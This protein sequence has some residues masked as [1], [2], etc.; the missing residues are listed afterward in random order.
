MKLLRG[1]NSLSSSV[2][3]QIGFLLFYAV[4]IHAGF[5]VLTL[6]FLT[7]AF[8]L[9][10]VAT[11]S[12]FLIGSKY[13][14]SKT[15]VLFYW[16]TWLEVSVHVFT[17][18]KIFGISL[19]V[20]LYYFVLISIGSYIFLIPYTRKL[21]ALFYCVC[22]V[23]NGVSYM[24]VKFLL[25]MPGMGFMLANPVYLTYFMYSVVMLCGM[26][27]LQ[28]FFFARCISIYF[29]SINEKNTELD[30]QAN[31]D[32][33]TELYNRRKMNESLQVAF[34]RH[35]VGF[36]PLSLCLGDIDNFKMI[37]DTYGHNAGDYVLKTIGRILKANIRKS[38]PVGRW[39]GEEFVFFM[40]ADENACYARA[41]SVRKEIESYEFVFEERRIPVTITFGVTSSGDDTPDVFSLVEKADRNLYRGKQGGRNQTVVG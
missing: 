16:V 11:I 6:I 5:L 24:A 20:E 9:F 35:K 13:A 26:V 10:Y 37:N 25:P 40:H 2:D 7:P 33:L 22:C 15:F 17:I 39:G 28:A 27:A 3:F 19:D 38:D 31:Y 23:V 21:K 32:V 30:H 34:E 36:V 4:I 41:E 14:N 12:L 1:S 8:S 18:W 29:A